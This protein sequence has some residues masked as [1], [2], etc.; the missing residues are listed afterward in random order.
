[1][2]SKWSIKNG[3]FELLQINPEN[4][5]KF[6]KLINDKVQSNLNNN[7]EYNSGIK[8]I[9]IGDKNFR[10]GG[11]GK[12]KLKIQG[13]SIELRPISSEA[14]EAAAKAASEA[15]HLN[16]TPQEVKQ[17]RLFRTTN[18]RSQLE[19]R[20]LWKVLRRI[21]EL[22]DNLELP[23]SDPN[24]ITA[25]TFESQL[26]KLIRTHGIQLPGLKPGEWN[27]GA[28]NKTIFG[29][30]KQIPEAFF[31]E[32]NYKAFMR[33]NYAVAQQVADEMKRLS[34]GTIDFDAGH[35]QQGGANIGL[36]SQLRYHMTQGNQ[37]VRGILPQFADL[38]KKAH[39]DVWGP[40]ALKKA[41]IPFDHVDGTLAYLKQYIGD[42]KTFDFSSIIPE[43]YRRSIVFDKEW[44]PDPEAGVDK[45][46]TKVFENQ[47]RKL[48]TVASQPERL[49][50]PEAPGRILQV[51]RG[52]KPIYQGPG[53]GILNKL[54]I[55][56]KRQLNQIINNLNPDN[57]ETR[58]LAKEIAQSVN[59][60]LNL[61]LI[62]KVS[63]QRLLSGA[64]RHI[65]KHGRMEAL[66]GILNPEVH[67]EALQGDV[68][69]AGTELARGAMIGGVT[70]M[71][72]SAAG[73]NLA[74]LS[75]I[76]IP[77]AVG[78]VGNVYLKH[79]T[80][81]G[82]KDRYMEQ[83]EHTPVTNEQT[84]ETTYVEDPGRTQRRNE[85]KQNLAATLLQIQ[86][87]KQIERENQKPFLNGINLQFFNR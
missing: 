23:K 36:I 38:F 4:K 9:K 21:K 45:A 48:Q 65:S 62:P 75:P 69:G 68:K 18:P 72:A 12:D 67:R 81:R 44:A 73:I 32:N 2:A 39:E 11:L 42:D 28:Y 6:I 8:S 30:I 85:A 70:S 80:G 33:K 87:R 25:Q 82:L 47:L 50:P 7:R 52:K 63:P 15:S 84:G 10:V 71:A 66:G 22:N 59:P 51:Q 61:S 13:T 19:S 16:R 31:D 60:Q 1:M 49:P 54:K 64:I 5:K 41:G 29:K 79:H 55:S 77:I 3:A 37:N 56:S 76:G 53:S 78:A 24:S 57:L 83:F 27:L 14:S 58:A 43:E 17:P 74:A 35:P 40:D 20:N 26:K 46:L 86:E 34:G